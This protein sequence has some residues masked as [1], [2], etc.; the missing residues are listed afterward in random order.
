MATSFDPH[1]LQATL[2]VAERRSL[3]NDA[4]HALHVY[5]KIGISR[6][7]GLEPTTCGLED[8]CSIQLSYW[9]KVLLC[10]MLL[11][12]MYGPNKPYLM[13]MPIGDLASIPTIL[14]IIQRRIMT[15]GSP[16]INCFQSVSVSSFQF[17][18]LYTVATDQAQGCRKLLRSI[19]D[20]YV[21]PFAYETQKGDS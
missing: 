2:A 15:A 16:K 13:P 4:P 11:D 10:R 7:A 17:P 12:L 19:F 6:Q 14:S 20:G 9:R 1:S 21:A 3:E 8:R 18:V 5:S